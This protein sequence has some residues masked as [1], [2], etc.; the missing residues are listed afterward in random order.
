M[1]IKLSLLALK[2]LLVCE[3]N[4]D[5][6]RAPLDMLFALLLPELDKFDGFWL[7]AD[8]RL[9]FELSRSDWDEE[10]SLVGLIDWG[11][12]VELFIVLRS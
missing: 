10:G 3:P 6:R 1:S 11:P 5:D 12:P 2:A 9:E 4:E 8:V 7:V